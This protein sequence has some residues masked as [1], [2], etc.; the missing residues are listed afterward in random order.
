[1]TIP[2]S[3]FVNRESTNG[4]SKSARFS[5]IWCNAEPR[6]RTRV[7]DAGGEM[8]GDPS[9]YNYALLPGIRNPDRAIGVGRAK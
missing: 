9:K 1:M 4:L 6:G 8:G 7:A 5:A 2:Q 3:S